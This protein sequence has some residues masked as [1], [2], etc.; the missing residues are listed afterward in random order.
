MS[1]LSRVHLP[2]SDAGTLS[3]RWKGPTF[4]SW[5]HFV[6]DFSPDDTFESLI[7]FVMPSN[8]GTYEENLSF[9]PAT[10]TRS[11]DNFSGC[12]RVS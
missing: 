4:L 9:P 1:G 7:T 10:G 5:S 6:Y 12:T 2:R 11:A 8:T 3:E